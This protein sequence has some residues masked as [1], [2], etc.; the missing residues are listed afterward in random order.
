MQKKKSN[1]KMNPN[2]NMLRNRLYDF[3][4]S[5]YTMPSINRPKEKTKPANDRLL[6][7]RLYSLNNKLIRE[8]KQKQTSLLVD[9]K[10]LKENQPRKFEQIWKDQMILGCTNPIKK[11]QLGN[12]SLDKRSHKEMDQSDVGNSK[13]DPLFGL[14]AKL[15]KN[16]RVK[17]PKIRECNKLKGR[18][19]EPMKQ[20]NEEE[21]I[22]SKHLINQLRDT[23]LQKTKCYRTE[24]KS[25]M[26]Q[27]VKDNSLR[28]TKPSKLPP[29][30]KKLFNPNA[31]KT[32]NKNSEKIMRQTELNTYIKLLQNKESQVDEFVYLIPRSKS[33]D[34][35]D[36]EL[37][38][39]FKIF[40]EE[41]ESG[42][43]A[44][45]SKKPKRHRGIRSGKS[46]TSQTSNNKSMN[47]QS[48]F[49]SRRTNKR[50]KGM[51]SRFRSKHNKSLKKEYYTISSKGLCHF[52]E[53]QPIE[54]IPLM[55]WMKERETYYKIKNL[56]FFTK[57]RKWKTVIMW[58]KSCK[59]LKQE[60]AR[61][62]LKEKLIFN[63]PELKR[64]SFEVKKIF[65]ELSQA[66]FINLNYTKE[67]SQDIGTIEDF[68][69]K[70]SKIARDVQIKIR[71]D[72][73]T[74]HEKVI[75]A[76]EA[77]LDILRNKLESK[78]ENDVSKKLEGKMI[79]R[80]N[81]NPYEN[82]NFP[83][84]LSYDRRSELEKECKRFIRFS[85]LVDFL[86]LNCLRTIHL[87]SLKYFYHELR[88]LNDDQDSKK[89]ISKYS[90]FKK[91]EPLFLVQLGLNSDYRTFNDDFTVQS[92]QVKDFKY[93]K[94]D[95]NEKELRRLQYKDFNLRTFPTLINY[96][97]KE[98]QENFNEQKKRLLEYTD[99][100]TFTQER[101]SNIEAVCLNFEP[102]ADTF[103]H[104]ISKMIMDGTH[105]LQSFESL[106]HNPSM[107]KYK[108][109]LDEWD[110]Q[111]DDKEAM[112]AP[113]I[114]SS[115]EWMDQDVK[116]DLLNKINKQFESA[117]QKSNSFLRKF[118][119]FLQIDYD[120][121]NLDWG[122]LTHVNLARPAVTFNAIFNVLDYHEHI[123][124]EKVPFQEDIGLLRIDSQ[125]VK[126][127]M[128]PR[129]QEIIS[130]LAKKIPEE[131]QKRLLSCQEWLVSQMNVLK[132]KTTSIDIFVEQSKNLKLIERRFPFFKDRL[133][134][135]R[136]IWESIRKFQIEV[137][138]DIV[139]LFSKTKELEQ[140]L[141]SEILSSNKSMA[142]NQDKFSKHIKE[143]LL[144][145]LTKECA[146]LEEMLGDQQLVD[147]T[148]NQ[149]VRSRSKMIK[150]LG[151]YQQVEII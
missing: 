8:V 33:E 40:E 55:E 97:L 35:Y 109:V 25:K 79:M 136:E 49:E 12:V 17:L 31:F 36:L 60:V 7:A 70:Q 151:Y 122:L 59:N 51:M 38:T 150:F 2:K 3:G 112:G 129:P 30:T 130:V 27:L 111:Q 137:G 1:K 16:S 66:K 21:L 142:K 139:Q 104:L 84:N 125:Q 146:K 103:I 148:Q 9:R 95:E 120:Y 62:L 72:S 144:P 76:F 81:N 127:Y 54:F 22:R 29:M 92:T 15:V 132:E 23:Y 82:L 6:V 10:K 26:S 98:Q 28:V 87:K 34:P 143:R 114:L 43:Q 83:E 41:E 96:D 147:H 123:F 110:G 140:D 115:E 119:H 94:I 77:Q 4:F 99:N 45:N 106:S 18:Y 80:A 61:K 102:S 46:M 37:K 93:P 107:K 44:K 50:T 101:I 126:E 57:F 75:A 48:L 116:K 118:R 124:N 86:A 20:I 11:E 52:K 13:H 58:R 141:D 56:E 131:L 67:A 134:T 42:T 63:C 100:K 128:I 133:K 88:I 91:K 108:A 47:G 105:N 73:Q 5:Q 14:K 74:C 19:E 78:E 90:S 117:F 24:P 89:T 39:Y 138:S 69:A 149:E 85:K 64:V 71:N 113:I 65:Y 145:G 121:T 32:N 53:G 135:C 68:V